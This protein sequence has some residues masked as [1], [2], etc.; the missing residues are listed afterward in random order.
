VVV[1]FETICILAGTLALTAGYYHSSLS[2]VGIGCFVVGSLWLVSQWRRWTW[3]ASLG[4]FVFVGAAVL[5]V[6]IGLRPIPMAFSVLGSL[7]AWDLADFSRRSQSAAPEDDL[8][9][10]EKKHLLRIAILGVAGLSL[11]LVAMY[12]HL[13]ISFGW[14]FLLAFAT[15]LG[16]MQLVKRFRQGG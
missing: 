15:V 7:L 6:W 9:R 14:M 8:R 3:V 11:S 10:L 4:L 13:Q 12:L 5:G 16:M 2:P 1:A